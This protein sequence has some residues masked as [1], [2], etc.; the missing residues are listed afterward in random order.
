MLLTEDEGRALLT[1]IV[2]TE[3]MWA[4][5]ATDLENHGEH[6]EARIAR[7]NMELLQSAKEKL[8]EAL[9]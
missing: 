9:A 2:L 6:S 3:D 7:R 8:E 4:E 1:S 5:A